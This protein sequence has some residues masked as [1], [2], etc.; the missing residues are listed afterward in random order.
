MTIHLPED[1]EQAIRAEV[2]SG[3]YPSE[4]AFVAEAIRAYF[5]QR[6]S[7][8]ERSGE[9]LPESTCDR[10]K[11]PEPVAIEPE[12]PPSIIGLF[13][14]EADLIRGCHCQHYAKAT[15]TDVETAHP[16]ISASSIRTS[17]PKLCERRTS[18]LSNMP[19]LIVSLVTA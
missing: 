17:S 12:T 14:D 11:E 16:G 15:V 9:G 19:R 6:R 7:S 5:Q 4:D 3:R 2:A 18:S 8:T 13:Q 10:T 1:L